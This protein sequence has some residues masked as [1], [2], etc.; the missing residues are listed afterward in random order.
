MLGALP[1]SAVLHARQARC[2]D[3]MRQPLRAIDEVE[4]A[5]RVL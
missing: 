4:N 3:E 5:R 1:P 2:Y